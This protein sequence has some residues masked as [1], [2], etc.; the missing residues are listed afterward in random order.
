MREIE[1][2]ACTT[3]ADCERCVELQKQVW[4]FADLEI[5]PLPLFVVFR[6]TGG[7]VLGA[8]DGREMVGF[9][10][11]LAAWRDGR[12]YLHSHMAAVLAAYQNRGVGRRLKLGQRDDAIRRGLELVEWTFDPLE[13]KNAYF[14][15]E[16]LGAICRHYRPNLYGRTTSPLHAGLPT[17]RL[18]AQWWVSTPRVETI[19]AGGRLAHGPHLERI[20]VPTEIDQMKRTDPGAGNRVQTQIRAR[21][22]E[23]FSQGYAVTGFERSE[24]GGTY[25]LEPDAN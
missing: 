16:R 6:E 4:A 15:I 12:A 20:L 11:A 25:L 8:F 9:V 24:A 19:V 7:E 2:R 10:A 18:V 3:L 1:I 17:D 13:I 5:V 14:N 23:L 21:F 22:L